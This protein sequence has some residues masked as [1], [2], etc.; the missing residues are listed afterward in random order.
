MAA[1]PAHVGFL[2]NP[3]FTGNQS[4]QPAPRAWVA[5][6]IRD[7]AGQL[8]AVKILSAFLDDYLYLAFDPSFTAPEGFPVYSICEIPHL[9][10]KMPETLKCIHQA[11]Q[12][13]YG[14]GRVLQ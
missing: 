5:D 4:G 3:Q 2:E 8:R 6:E 1:D 7:E 11:R 12:I 10:R 14:R 13:F 9:G